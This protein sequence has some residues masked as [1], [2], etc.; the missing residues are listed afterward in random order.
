M[1]RPRRDGKPST[2][3][4]RRKLSKAIIKA[5]KPRGG[6]PYTVWDTTTRGLA[7]RVH[8]DSMTWKVVY[9]RHGR[10]RWY[11]IGNV[12]TIQLNEARTMAC[13]IMLRVGAGEDPQAERRAER[14][15]GTFADLATRYANY[16]KK[17]NK[18]W[19]QTNVLIKNY[20]LP[21]WGELLAADIKR[22]DAKALMASIT[23]PIAANQIIAAASSMFMWAIKEEVGGVKVNPC[24]GVERNKARPTI[25]HRAIRTGNESASSGFTAAVRLPAFPGYFAPRTAAGTFQTFEI[26]M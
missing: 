4:D 26:T 2:A 21:K 15:A 16:A 9:S 7:I 11:H 13:K 25:R 18:S 14:D 24:V 23:A 17:K 22:S 20:L 10:P 5:L 12:S 3:P 1:A 6:R 8:S 19:E